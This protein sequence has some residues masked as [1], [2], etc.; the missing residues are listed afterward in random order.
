MYRTGFASSQSAYESAVTLLFQSLDKIE[1]ILSGSGREYLIGDQL[2][3]ADVRLYVTII[4]FDP[5]YFGN[6]K[7]NLKDIRTG[8][9]T[10]HK[11]VRNL[12]WK[13]PAFKDTTNFEHIKTGY[14]S[15][16]KVCNAQISLVE[17]ADVL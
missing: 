14:F 2:S 16:T 3:E 4:R 1:S 8:Y 15:I 6:F 13:N 7:C 9:P 5:A 10:I 11:W 17:C 12:Y